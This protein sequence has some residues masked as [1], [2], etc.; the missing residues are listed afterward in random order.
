MLVQPCKRFRTTCDVS[1]IIAKTWYFEPSL[2]VSAGIPEETCIG[3]SKYHFFAIISG[4]PQVFLKRFQ[5][6]INIRLIFLFPWL[7]WG[8]DISDFERSSDFDHLQPPA[9]AIF[10]IEDLQSISLRV[11][12]KKIL[13]FFSDILKKILSFPKI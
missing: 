8:D 12:Q 6:R 5:G 9:G 1:E 4:K 13:K 2:H 11:T 7:D 10:D 3:G